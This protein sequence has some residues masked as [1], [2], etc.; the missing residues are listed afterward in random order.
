MRK[1]LGFILLL[2]LMA[3]PSRAGA[4]NAIQFETLNIGLWSEYDQPSMLVITEFVVSQDTPVP[5][6][7]TMRFPKKG[8][9]MAVAVEQGG[10]LFNATFEGPE[11]QG[12]WQTIK[13]NVESYDVYRVEYYQPFTQ[14]GNKREFNYQWSGEYAVKDFSVNILIPADSANVVSSP[15]LSDTSSADGAIVGSVSKSGLGAGQSYDF[16]LEYT[17]E[18]DA[19]MKPGDANSVQPSEPIGT[20]TTGRVAIDKIP[21]V[22]GG[23]GVVL[24]VIALFFYWRSTQSSESTPRRRRRQSSEETVEGQAYCHECGA[25]AHE[26]DRFCRTCGSRLRTGQ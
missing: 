18:S 12:N 24:I 15:I 2:G 13:I 9:L 5:A 6:T 21:Y 4:Q 20:D 19:V 7:V 17:R 14:D 25:R 3:Y 16:K 22:I 10:K 8:N 11:E 1:W 26:G 23:V